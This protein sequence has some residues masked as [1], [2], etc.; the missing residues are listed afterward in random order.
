MIYRL[1][2]SSDTFRETLK[3]YSSNR[4]DQILMSG[5][6]AKHCRTSRMMGLPSLALKKEKRQIERVVALKCSGLPLA[7]P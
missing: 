3:K 5:Q 1:E 7:T 2:R 6:I 4:C